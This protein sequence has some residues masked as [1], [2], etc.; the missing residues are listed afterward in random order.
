MYEAWAIADGSPPAPVGSFTVGADGIG[1][2]DRMPSSSGDTLTVAITLELRPDP[3][4][5][6]TPIIASGVTVPSGGVAS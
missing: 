1:Y 5:P 3:P 6:T 4:A 2:F